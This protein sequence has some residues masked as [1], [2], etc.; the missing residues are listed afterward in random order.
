M[1]SYVP[2][3]IASAVCFVLVAGAASSWHYWK[4]KRIA[5]EPRLAEPFPKTSPSS[6]TSRTEAASEVPAALR[7]LHEAETDD[8]VQLVLALRERLDTVKQR[9]AKVESREDLLKLI[10]DD[11][12]AEQAKVDTLRKTIDERLRRHLTEMQVS[13]DKDPAQKD[14]AEPTGEEEGVSKEKTESAPENLAQ[15]AAQ[16]ERNLKR[17]ASVY[18]TMAPEITSE[19]FRQ[20]AEDGSTETVLRLLS[21]MKERQAGK[22]L[23]ELSKSAPQLSA[24]LT[25]KLRLLKPPPGSNAAKS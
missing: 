21:L 5:P 17:M 10:H 22:V 25:E 1:K 2:V 11:I 6:E 12:E 20:L 9:E 8:P 16:E 19:I 15:S 13:G 7:P 4:G 23:T 3:L 24:E 18:D 14:L